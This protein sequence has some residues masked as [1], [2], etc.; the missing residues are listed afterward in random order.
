[1]K[2]LPEQFRQYHPTLGHGDHTEGYF[3]VPYGRRP[4]IA[5]LRVI[6]SQGLLWDH[7]SVSLP[8]RC[9]TWQEMC[10]V[11][12]LFFH[13]HETVIQFHPAKKDYVNFHPNCLH[14]WRPQQ[15]TIPMPPLDTI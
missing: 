12:D 3:L 9:P 1:M 8:T 13:D 15:E 5:C 7:V 2:T 10:H 14:L 4:H 11:K 6:A